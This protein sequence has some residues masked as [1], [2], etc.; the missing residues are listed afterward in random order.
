MR[1][2]DFEP[3]VVYYFK[4]RDSFASVLFIRSQ[5]PA[6]A[7][8]AQPTRRNLIAKLMET[9]GRDKDSYQAA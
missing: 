5:M 9:Y 2:A 8:I 6:G 3:F 1:H 4:L 7:G